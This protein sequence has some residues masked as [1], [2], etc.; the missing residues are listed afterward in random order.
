MRM[1]HVP[2]FTDTERATQIREL[3]VVPFDLDKFGSDLAARDP[4]SCG[5][6]VVSSI[7]G[8]S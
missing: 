5:V 3:E 8:R 7:V 4:A 1:R 6:L 2:F